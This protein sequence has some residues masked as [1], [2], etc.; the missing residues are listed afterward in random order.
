MGYKSFVRA[1]GADIRRAERNAIRRQKELEKIHK[2]QTKMEELQ[3]A[4]YEVEKFN[5]IIEQL[6]TI[7]HDCTDKIDWNAI[8]N[9][10]PPSKPVESFDNKYNAEKKLEQFK[11]NFLQK[12]FKLEKKIIAELE[13]SIKKAENADRIKNQE[14]LNKYQNE[15]LE[16]EQMQEIA[17]GILKGDLKSY[18]N[19]IEYIE[20]FE[21][22]KDLGCSVKVNICDKEKAEV[23]LITQSDSA[24]PKQA[25]SL[26]KS[27]KLSVKEMPIGKFNELYQDYVCSAVLRVGREV[28]A[29][30]PITQIIVTSKTNLLD[31]STGR[32]AEQPVIS[33]LLSRETLNS[34]NFEA[35]D[36][37]DCMK[38][39][40]HNM[41]F[42]KSAGMSVVDIVSW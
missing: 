34:F 30:L 29:I 22:L 13:T 37:S 21:E 23:E 28:F 11:P 31:S 10:N 5:L 1:V 17:S 40:K 18:S 12:L 15:L 39:F 16:H 6:T 3:M 27:G 9:T 7:H 8:K 42:K 4:A 14:K 36:P 20:P 33:V 26:L 25:K 35:I 24:I 2:L 32:F 41:G 19:A 38:N